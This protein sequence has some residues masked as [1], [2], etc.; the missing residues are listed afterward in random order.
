[1]TGESAETSFSSNFLPCE[2]YSRSQADPGFAEM[3][4][5]GQVCSFL[6]LD[7]SKERS[8]DEPL[9]EIKTGEASPPGEG[10]IDE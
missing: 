6:S 2:L 4:Q 9:R 10:F 7:S 5:K 3:S 8:R 1:M